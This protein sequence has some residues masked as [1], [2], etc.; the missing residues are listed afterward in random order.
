MGYSGQPMKVIKAIRSLLRKRGSF[1]DIRKSYE[2]YIEEAQLSFK[3][4]TGFEQ[5]S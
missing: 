4:P 5:K 2:G 1:T 3:Q